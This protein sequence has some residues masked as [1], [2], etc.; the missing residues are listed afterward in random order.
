MHKL[1]F[2]RNCHLRRCREEKLTDTASLYIVATPIGNLSDMSQR[3]VDTLKFVDFIAAEDTRHS[4][5]LLSRYGIDTPMVALH[6][7]NEEQQV[8]LLLTRLEDGQSIAL[9]SDAG[10]PLISDPG[11]IVVNA[12][13]E[14]GFSV[15]AVP[16]PSAI[17][18][19]LSIA[20]LP[21]HQFTFWGFLPAKSQAR[22]DVLTSMRHLQQTSVFYE[23]THRLIPALQDMVNILG[24]DREIAVVKELTKKHERVIRNSAELVLD[25]FIQD[26]VLQK[27]EFVIIV[28][29]SEDKLDDARLLVDKHLTLFLSQVS[30]KQAVKLTVALTGGNKNQIYERALELNE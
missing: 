29:G 2:Y 12:V 6:D 18:A 5:P 20:G 10:T 27:G 11:Y 4:K 3:A 9:I 15:V 23:S 17:V 28:K 13:R 8:Q 19:A 26:S 1:S 16:G 22:Q 7:H 21:T 14:A 25:T 24:N 30:V